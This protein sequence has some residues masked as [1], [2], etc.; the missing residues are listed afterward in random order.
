MT[1]I[2][3]D[4]GF[5][6]EKEAQLIVE[7]SHLDYF[8]TQS[9]SLE[10]GELVFYVAKDRHLTVT[11]VDFLESNLKLRVDAS[12]AKNSSFEIQI[13]SLCP[14]KKTKVFDVNV[15]HLDTDTYSRTKMAGINL[16]SGTLRFLG[17]S[18][19][20]NGAHRSDTR[21]EGRITNLSPLSHSEC[22]PALLINDNDVKASHGAALGAYNPDV[23][24]YLMSR[25]LSLEESKKLITYGT[26]LPIIE[27]LQDKELI[28]AA[29]TA[30]GELHL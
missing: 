15:H 23:L 26:L 17:N 16:G 29:S 22:S 5:L 11:I 28:N 9:S 6:S 3:K 8:L 19:I 12:L 13:A 27:S 24:Y 30:L 18:M 20:K 7:D 2:I 1:D 4:T 10:E 21:Q 25:G 14:D